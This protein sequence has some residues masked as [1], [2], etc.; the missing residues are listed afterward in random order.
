MM[1]PDDLLAEYVDGTLEPPERAEVDAHLA[2]CG[3]CRADLRS[4]LRARDELRGAPEAEMPADLRERILADVASRPAPA[5]TAPITSLG[6]A[7]ERRR[8]APAAW[9]AGIAAAAALLIG[10]FM[11]SSLH[12]TS[13]PTGAVDRAAAPEANATVPGQFTGGASA[14][15]VRQPDR[16]YNQVAIQRLAAAATT[17]GV[18]FG[19][20]PVGDATGAIACLAKGAK[21]SGSEQPMELIQAKFT[22]KPAYL[23]IYRVIGTGDT[24]DRVEVWVVSMADCSVLSFAQQLIR[25]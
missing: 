1:H 4:S 11:F 20:R 9:L 14:A 18:Q 10:F 15:L 7:G 17:G 3:R 12:S 21:I 5:P 23:G 2:G 8:L 13:F 24:P 22:G 25:S 19:A 16:N 6:R